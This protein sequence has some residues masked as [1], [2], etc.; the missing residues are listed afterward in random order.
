M[1]TPIAR[2]WAGINVIAAG[3][4]QNLFPAITAVYSPYLDVRHGQVSRH[5][6]MED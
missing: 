3:V 5:R 4:P 1:D 2:A 6:A